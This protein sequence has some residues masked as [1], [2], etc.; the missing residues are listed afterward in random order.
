[1]CVCY[2]ASLP[3]LGGSPPGGWSPPGVSQAA[4]SLDFG[5]ELSPSQSARICF[6]PPRLLPHRSAP[7]PSPWSLGGANGFPDSRGPARGRRPLAVGANPPGDL[8]TAAGLSPLALI[9]YDRCV[10]CVPPSVEDGWHLFLICP[11]YSSL[12]RSMPFTAEELCVEGH[13]QQGQGCSRRN[14]QS[15]M[16]AILR[17]NRV[18]FLVDYLTKAF[19]LRKS[20]R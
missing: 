4:A 18:E 15:L 16:N 7:P 10:E 1:M 17:S 11:L 5:E 14:L 6:P 19:K 9:E 20:Y 3:P 12:R 13:D 2:S 8:G